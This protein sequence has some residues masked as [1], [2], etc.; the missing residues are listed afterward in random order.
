MKRTCLFVAAILLSAATYVLW[1]AE[2][3]ILNLQVTSSASSSASD[4]GPTEQH[5]PWMPLGGPYERVTYALAIDVQNGRLYA[6]TWGHGVYRSTN[7]G[8]SWLR[9][10]ID[11]GRYVRCLSILPSEAA[12]VT[13]YA[14]TSGEGLFRSA[15][16]GRHWEQFG[17]FQSFTEP[18]PYP[19][20]RLR[21]E[22]LLITSDGE[23]GR[24]Y[25]GT[26]DGVWFS[27]V[28][29]DVWKP[30]YF[31]SHM[32]DDAYT[33]RALAQD[34][35]GRIYAGTYDG[36]YV[37]Q[38]GG[39]DWQH[40]E[41]PQ[42]YPEDASR[43]LSLAVVT[44]T[45]QAGQ[46]LLIGTKKAG[47]Y[48]LDV[49]NRTWSKR[50]NG[51]HESEDANTIQALISTP[52]GWTYAG[53]VD[54]G[55]YASQDGGQSWQQIV[56]GLP[57][58][59][60]SIL[61]FAFDPNDGTLYAGT[62]GDGVYKLRAGGKRWEEAKGKVKIK[63]GE[64][65]DER[66]PVD[67]PVQEMVF[68]GKKRQ[69]LFAALQVGGLYLMADRENPDSSWLRVPEALPIG[70]ARDAA[71]VAT[72]G[73]N[74]TTLVI[75]AGTGVFRKAGPGADWQQLGTKAGLPAEEVRALAMTQGRRNPDVLY[76]ALAGG[77]AIYRSENA[78]ETWEPALGDFT[79]VLTPFISTLAVGDSDDVVYLGLDLRESPQSG[80]V[81]DVGQLYV[82][83]NRGVNWVRLTPIGD[84]H[85]L[86]LDWSQRS[87]LDVFLHGGQRRMLYARTAE[88]I[89]ISY[90]GGESWQLRLRGFFS[91]L[92]ANP[93]RRWLVYA[94]SPETKLDREYAPPIELTSDLWISN[95]GGERW[96]WTGDGP[97]LQDAESPASITALA[98]D[99]T[100]KSRLYAGTDGAGVFQ[101]T[102]VGLGRSF[103]LWAFLALIALVLF[104]LG[105]GYVVSTGWRLGRP[106]GLPL[107]TWPMLAH[108]QL[109]RRNQIHLVAE[110]EQLAALERLA[111]AYAPSESFRPSA[112]AQALEADRV[113]ADPDQ[114][115][116]TLDRLVK[117]HRLL[118]CP[119]VGNYRQL[120][121]LLGQIAQAR[122]LAQ[123]EK[124]RLIEE[125]RSQN[126]LRLEVRLF[127]RS[128]GLED[129]AYDTGLKVISSL[130][131]YALLG[132]ERGIYVHVQTASRLDAPQVQELRDNA[133]RAYEGQLDGKLAFLVVNGRPELDTYWQIAR[134]G[135]EEN[136]R[137]VLLSANRVREAIQSPTSRQMLDGYLQRA[138]GN[139]DLFQLSG[140]ALDPLDFFGRDTEME[141]LA[142][143]CRQ[144]RV[145]GLTGM[146]KVGK[147]SLARQMT[148]RLAGS[149]VAWIGPE[150]T[151]TTGL[152]A[153]LRQSWLEGARVKFPMWVQPQWEAPPQQPASAHIAA[154]LEMI[155]DSLA[156]QASAIHLL[157][158]LD[159]V[160][161]LSTGTEEVQTLAQA[162][163]ETERTSL[164]GISEAWR[165][166]LDFFQAFVPLLPFGAENSRNLIDVLAIQ[167]GLE[168]E[169]AA[170]DELQ[171]AS[172][173][174]PLILRQLAS[175]AV[176]HRASDDPI[177]S[178]TD[179]EKGIAKYI[180]DPNASIREIWDRLSEDEQQALWSAIKGE[181]TPTE[182]VL[183]KLSELG[184]LTPAEDR[185]GLF[186]EAMARWLKSQVSS[187]T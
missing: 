120:S 6:G 51:F 55:V 19:R 140:P 97:K 171:R 162:I 21:V 12:T 129:S 30:L 165:R 148:N 178:V 103:T 155:C 174:H 117:N 25:A 95:D 92:L 56:E 163:A 111:F 64:V 73:E 1:P 173:G 121:L 7:G 181:A 142:E 159:G 167:M 152:Y 34:S 67:F 9:Q 186:S 57:P 96:T 99:P 52:D 35:K 144:G 72:C 145:I 23:V 20:S 138:L 161:D 125:I 151:I 91:A 88:G 58:H 108:L 118:E 153:A 33:I 16:G 184:W 82:T 29:S 3:G 123:P 143:L 18:A 149:L 5:L 122:F 44:D 15:D 127:F 89:Y 185:W 77:S 180:A 86:E 147:T 134:L 141:K 107:R 114:L 14:G 116:K 157:A 187:L 26:H 128:V 104:L 42:D 183:E 106:Y 37:T 28:G 93:Y 172:G 8:E 4:D 158:V 47:V 13:V 115:E 43:I 61:S 156:T 40:L 32:P 133:E 84:Q 27:T 168:F 100:H 62:Y 80:Q 169:L 76:T 85:V 60:R 63:N 66:L 170:K 98:I 79:T 45:T 146:G 65:K 90:D 49:E 71:S 176:T 105:T 137:L 46:T 11:I 175:L 74:R 17:Q 101:A 164:L 48:V 132:A 160:D 131:E 81:A 94:A 50:G 22:S 113:P 39:E 38:N 130:P 166:R 150:V 2:G 59:A 83:H 126:R 110:S 109:V 75:A 78:G 41:P 182:D 70:A 54:F 87:W 68:A 124:D 135:R 69:D 53:V 119:E 102:P 36:L 177:I 10:G 139:Q 154:D 31:G 24:I 136:L 112:I 179:V